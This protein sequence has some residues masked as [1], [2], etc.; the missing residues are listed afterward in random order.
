[1]NALYKFWLSIRA[2]LF[3]LLFLPNITLFAILIN[4]S[5]LLPFWFRIGLIRIWI[6]TSLAWLKLTCN[7]GYKVEGLE[8]IPDDGFII[9]SKHS[10]TWETIALQKWFRPMAWVVKRELIWIPFFGWG[11]KG[12]EAIAI[13]RGTG[14]QAIRQLIEEGRNRMDQGRIVMLF[15]EG[16]RVMPGQYKP[17]KLG[18]AILSQKTGYSIL[19]VAHNAGEFWPRHSWIKWPGT[20]R[21]V[22]GPP[23]APEGRKPDQIIKEVEQ[24]VIGTCEKISDHE[25]LKKLNIENE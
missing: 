12:M 22:I 17:F 9:M 16:T 25:Q 23:I 3:W 5:L 14:R 10:S 4:L 19:P 8:N 2:G 13:N 20:I 15:P 18:G 24:W 6:M 21:V 11:L 1:M 7:L